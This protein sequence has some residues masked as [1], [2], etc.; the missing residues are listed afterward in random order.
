[1]Y[2]LVCLRY[3]EPHMPRKPKQILNDFKPPNNIAIKAI[4]K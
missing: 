3:A 1:M 4:V 2:V